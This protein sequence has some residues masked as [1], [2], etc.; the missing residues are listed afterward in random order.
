MIRIRSAWRRTY[1]RV[2]CIVLTAVV[3]T[4]MEAQAQA[5]LPQGGTRVRVTYPCD[6]DTTGPAGFSRNTCGVVG[7]FLTIESSTVSVVVDGAS[8]TFRLDDVRRFEVS[9]GARSYR[10]IGS[11]AGFAVGSGTTYIALNRGGST[12]K[13]DRSAN[14]DALSSRECF[15]LV[16]LGGVVG[17]GVGLLLGGFIKSERWEDL[18]LEQLRVSVLHDRLAV[19]MVLLR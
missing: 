7:Q 11:L 6:A 15:G 16:A 17:A 4:T 19:R 5:E 1:S 14:Q 18:A 2:S 12:S 13:C 3:I 8:R 10:L 9:Q